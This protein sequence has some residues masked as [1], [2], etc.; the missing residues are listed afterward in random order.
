MGKGLRSLFTSALPR[1]SSPAATAGLDRRSPQERELVR[2]AFAQARNHAVAEA[3]AWAASRAAE[4]VVSEQLKTYRTRELPRHTRQATRQDYLQW[5]RGFL[6]AGGTPTS[7]YDRPFRA[8]EEWLV[9]RED[10]TIRP[11][12]GASSVHLLV[13]SG[14]QVAGDPGHTSLY[15]VE[16]YRVAGLLQVPEY[17][18]TGIDDV[19]KGV[20]AAQRAVVLDR[21]HEFHQQQRKF[22]LEHLQHRKRAD[23]S[24][25]RARRYH[26]DVLAHCTR[27]ATRGDYLAWL[28]AHVLAGG[29]ITHSYDYPWENVAR[30]T[31][32]LEVQRKW[33]VAT[34]DVP[35]QPFYGA[36]AFQVILPPGL[37]TTGERG[38]SNVYSFN[39]VSR[40]LTFVPL[41]A[42]LEI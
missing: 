42:D 23:D 15:L 28:A 36:L 19:L 7:R 13:P 34:A 39:Q 24:A 32:S 20:D 17:D 21:L 2:A 11:L 31:R 4:N 18:D 40:P 35:L 6:L 10:F 16:G 1:I 22:E 29:R 8:G 14:I 26:E 37:V 41:Y 5:L 9:A 27:P 12:H 30:P 3:Q 33:L 25:E 38:H